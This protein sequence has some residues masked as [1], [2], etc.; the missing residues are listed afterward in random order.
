VNDGVFLKVA[1]TRDQ[2]AAEAEALRAFGRHRAVEVH[3]VRIADHTLVL[4]RAHPGASL[5]SLATEDEAM[6]VLVRLLAP[7]WP[8]VPEGAVA[9]PLAT[10]AR[11]LDGRQPALGRAA[12]LLAELL[13]D[14]RDVALLHGDLHYENILSSDRAGYLLIDPQGVVGEPAFDIGYLV[15]RPAPAA[16]DALPLPRAIDR[17]LGFLPDALGLEPRRVAAYAYVAAALSMAWAV[18]DRDDS[19]DAFEAAMRLLE[20]RRGVRR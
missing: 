7:A 15:S 11:S 12:G 14:E 10:F 9:E 1:R 2:L 6:R 13:Q 4:E 5:A 8:P 17:R 18:E 20:P 3:E 19:R 16:R